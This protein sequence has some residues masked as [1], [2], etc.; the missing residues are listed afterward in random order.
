MKTSSVRSNTDGDVLLK[1]DDYWGLDGSLAQEASP[2]ALGLGRNQSHTHSQHR[3]VDLLDMTMSTTGSIGLND[4]RKPRLQQQGS[5][6]DDFQQ[7][8]HLTAAPTAPPAPAGRDRDRDRDSIP[9]YYDDDEDEDELDRGQ[10]RS[11]GYYQ[12]GY[13]HSSSRPMSTFSTPIAP[14]PAQVP[15][16]MASTSSAS[17]GA[18]TQPYSQPKPMNRTYTPAS[19]SAAVPVVA[20]DDR[21]RDR[22]RVPRLS[23]TTGRRAE[24]ARSQDK[25]VAPATVSR[26]SSTMKA[27]PNQPSSTPRGVSPGPRKSISTAGRPS[28]DQAALEEKAAALQAEIE[29]YQL[30]NAKI[31]KARA[32]AEGYE[33]ELRAAKED[34]IK[35]CSEEKAATLAWCKEQRAIIEK[36]RRAAAKQASES[37]QKAASGAAPIRNQKADLEAAQQAY[38][39]LKATHDASVRKAKAE[40]NRLYGVIQNHQLQVS[41][42]EQQ[43]YSLEQHQIT[44][45]EFISD[46]GLRL[47]KAIRNKVIAPEP[48]AAVADKSKTMSF[49]QNRRM[50]DKGYV[51]EVDVEEVNHFQQPA[52]SD[53][54]PVRGGAKGLSATLG[55]RPSSAAKQSAH[56]QAEPVAN[57]WAR[58]SRSSTRSRYSAGS[59]D[60]DLGEEGYQEDMALVP[61][62]GDSRDSR[63]VD[64]MRGTGSWQQSHTP[65]ASMSKTMP[66]ASSRP[67]SQ[68]IAAPSSSGHHH[69]Q[70]TAA[71]AAA[72]GS[73]RIE[74][75]LSD[76][77]RCI[78]YRN[79]TIK[80]IDPQGTTTVQFLNGDTKRSDA[81]GVVV[82]FYKQAATTHTT[83]PDGMEVYEFPNGQVEKHYPDCRKEVIFPD[84][85]R[86]VIAPDGTQDSYYPDG[87]VLR[88][89]TDGRQ[90]MVSK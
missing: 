38:D 88:E 80:I 26:P 76:G 23:A 46:Q 49:A 20:P 85:T 68:G 1:G 10:R 75:V 56:A 67:S 72:D 16:A 7:M 22:D 62:I 36:E 18:T 52:L 4:W 66:S 64:I 12:D 13:E 70:E 5:G 35:R 89:H 54:P 37:R 58:S 83:H 69:H 30:E 45:L 41:N 29:S 33:K 9:S 40:A 42:L 55:A 6:L 21:D 15:A 79:G 2:A 25:P 53:D 47:P 51:E 60:E 48:A 78:H 43:V 71:A 87:V 8:E 34:A 90:E 84:H 57:S 39:K 28:V 14:V 77:S 74:E 50:S 27:R 44:L 73:G 65:A 59:F 19:A 17:W 86:K 11:N 31:K 3:E 63:D 81:R 32:Q 24:A 61:G 82:Y